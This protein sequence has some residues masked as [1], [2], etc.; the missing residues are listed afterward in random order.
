MS[1]P[2]P[3]VHR[4]RAAPLPR[5][6][7][8]QV[9]LSW[10]T[11]LSERLTEALWQAVC[12][13]MALLALALSGALLWLPGWLHGGLVMFCGAAFGGLLVSGLQNLHWPSKAEAEARLDQS[14]PHHPL[15]ALRDLWQPAPGAGSP[16]SQALWRAHQTQARA[17]LSR[18]K[19]LPPRP[20]LAQRDPWGLRFVP[21]FALVLALPLVHGDALNR[22]RVAF[23]PDWG[24]ASAAHS[25]TVDLWITPPAYTGAPSV[26]RRQ[27]R[28]GQ[29]GQQA[30]LPPPAS[31]ASSDGPLA[32]P[33]GSQVVVLIHQARQPV[34]EIADQALSTSPLAPQQGHD[35][36]SFRLD[37]TLSAPTDP[38]QSLR[39]LDQGAEIARWP[40]IITPDLPPQVAFRSPPSQESRKG[41][42]LLPY[43]ISDD[44]GVTALTAEISRPDQPP[45]LFPLP[46][47]AAIGTGPLQGQAVLSL[48]SD[49]WAGLP[50]TLRLTATDAAGSLAVTPA[51]PLTL[52]ERA[53]SNPVARKI[54]AIRRA[55]IDAPARQREQHLSALAALAEDTQGYQGTLSVFMALRVATI[56]LAYGPYPVGWPHVAQPDVIDLLWQAAVRVEEGTRGDAEQRMMDAQAALDE[57]LA[58]NASSQEIAEKIQQLRLAIQDYMRALLAQMPQLSPEDLAF[59]QG[60]PSPS[61][62]GASVDPE[63]L[64]SLLRHLHELDSLG[65]HAAAQALRA[66]IAEMVN[67]LRRAQPPDAQA[68]RA[69]RQS[70]GALSQVIEQQKKVLDQT[71]A[72]QTGS[73]DQRLAR[74]PALAEAQQQAAQSLRALGQGLPLP[75]A[76]QQAEEA[77]ETAHSELDQGNLYRANDAQQ[78][79]L[80]ALQSGAQQM[81]RQMMQSLSQS[82]SAPLLLPGSPHGSGSGR[83]DPLAQSPNTTEGETTLPGEGTASR[84]R[85][86]QNELRRRANDPTL[87]PDERTYIRR[88]LEPF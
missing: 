78:E 69:L 49:R 29:Q 83:P 28:Q 31:P 22:L 86:I 71:F 73:R 44:Y 75:P 37:T 67:T 13:L 60:L 58:N 50:V 74:A 57:A 24:R 12:V 32:V 48:A 81:M 40:L 34:V 19:V 63:S 21:L 70:M 54:A 35:N 64:D 6:L 51:V 36:G 77:M 33:Q 68:L 88:L 30:T 47:P 56:R 16:L 5:V 15:R 43:Q 11:L 61:Q 20:I 65:A 72:A 9:A 26:Q 41:Q 17:A 62:D 79:A 1:D 85:S 23:S 76:L 80:S 52:P 82:Q 8:G 2:R 10:L 39:V 25:Q 7:R 27:G 66:Q 53:F 84:A 38:Q 45:R 3:D 4:P 18:L 42:L 46:L 87:S 14:A 59:L 55:I